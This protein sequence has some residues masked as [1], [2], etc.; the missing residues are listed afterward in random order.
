[1]ISLHMKTLAVV[2]LF[3]GF[4]IPKAGAASVSYVISENESEYAE[5]MNETHQT[6]GKKQVLVFKTN[7]VLSFS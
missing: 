6:P 7:F 2:A 5:L 1:M 3:G 4:L